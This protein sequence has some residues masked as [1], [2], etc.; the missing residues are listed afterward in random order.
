MYKGFVQD[1]TIVKMSTKI[2]RDRFKSISWRKTEST[3]SE[4][5]GQFNTCYTKDWAKQTHPNENSTFKYDI[6]L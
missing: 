1:R 4:S 6:V 5:N 2:Q 3:I